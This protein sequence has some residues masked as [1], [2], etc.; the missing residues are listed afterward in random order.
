MTTLDMSKEAKA[1]R[2]AQGIECAGRYTMRELKEL[3]KNA[4]LMD[5]KEEISILNWACLHKAGAF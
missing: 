5:D 2:K 3:R 1:K 4:R